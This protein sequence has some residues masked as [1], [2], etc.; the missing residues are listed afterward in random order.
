MPGGWS[1][2]VGLKTQSTPGAKLG[3]IVKLCVAAVVRAPVAKFVTQKSIQNAN[4]PEKKTKTGAMTND[5]LKP[6]TIYDSYPGSDLL[7]VD[8]PTADETFHDYINR[9]GK[10]NIRECGDTLFA[11]IEAEDLEAAV[12]MLDRALDDI[13]HVRR[14]IDGWQTIT[15]E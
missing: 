10:Q 4:R 11:L 14:A 6:K 5:L 7:A 3:D 1:L 12:H 9:V 15:E 8:P 13:L 2:V